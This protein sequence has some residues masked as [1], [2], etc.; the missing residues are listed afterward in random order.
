MSRGREG[1]EG[2][3]RGR[4]GERRGREGEGRGREGERRGRE[5]ERRGREGERRGREGERRGREGER[6]GREGERRGGEG[7]VGG[8]GKEKAGRG[9][10]E[11][12]GGR[13]REVVW[14]HVSRGREGGTVGGLYFI[15]TCRHLQRGGHIQSFAIVSEE[16]IAKGIRRIVALT[17]RE[18]EKVNSI[19]VYIDRDSF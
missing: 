5:G 14:G 12:E 4:E 9:E 3:R 18:A 13:G 2:E 16:A 10:K 17:G 1:R 19:A 7:S 8:R 15:V 6:R 11:R